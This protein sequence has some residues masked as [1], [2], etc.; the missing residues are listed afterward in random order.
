MPALSD[1]IKIS[2]FKPLS[3]YHNPINIGRSDYFMSRKKALPPPLGFIIIGVDA[4]NLPF[5]GKTMLIFHQR[6]R[7]QEAK[8]KRRLRAA[9]YS[10]SAFRTS[11][12]H[13]MDLMWN[14]PDEFENLWPLDSGI[15]SRAGTKQNIDQ[16]IY[17][18]PD[19]KRPCAVSMPIG[20]ARAIYPMSTRRFVINSFKLP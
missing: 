18:R 12:D 10:W 6:N 11:P 4:I 14:G 20:L 15:N 7:G 13:V 8:F 5:I 17:F 2:W 16:Q 3:A 1:R 19:S 9:G